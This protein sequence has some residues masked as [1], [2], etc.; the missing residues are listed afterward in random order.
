MGMIQHGSPSRHEIKEWIKSLRQEGVP[1][2]KSVKNIA[3]VLAHP[4]IIRAMMLKCWK[5]KEG[6]S[7]GEQLVELKKWRSMWFFDIMEAMKY[8]QVPTFQHIHTIP[9]VRELIRLRT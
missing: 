7:A 5:G 4:Q 8:L 9:C 6:S 1:V 3:D 2:L